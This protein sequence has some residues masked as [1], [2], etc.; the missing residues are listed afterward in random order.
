MQPWFALMTQDKTLVRQE[1]PAHR[2]GILYI[3]SFFMI[4]V[5]SG[6]GQFFILRELSWQSNVSSTVVRLVDEGL[7]ESPLSLAALALVAEQ[8]PAKRGPLLESLRKAIEQLQAA[9]G[10]AAANSEKHSETEALSTGAARL[11]SKAEARRCEARRFAT[12]LLALL[13][14]KGAVP[15]LPAEVPT[16]LQGI[17]AEEA[18]ATRDVNEVVR[19]GGAAAVEQ[20]SRLEQF[21]FKLFG[22]VLIVLVLEGLFVVNPAVRK[23]RLS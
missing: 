8:D 15:P 13:G 20:F 10:G 23:I 5:L 16:L 18:A 2:L 7:L 1:S 21:E 12:D 22:L 6:F 14:R 9:K 17:L 4:T 11:L 19:S 3:A